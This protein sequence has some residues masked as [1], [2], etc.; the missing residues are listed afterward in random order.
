MHGLEIGAQLMIRIIKLICMLCSIV[1]RIK[2]LLLII[3]RTDGVWYFHIVTLIQK[4]YA[5]VLVTSW[6]PP[7][8]IL[9]TDLNYNVYLLSIQCVRCLIKNNNKSM[10]EFILDSSL[11]EQWPQ[12][13]LVSR[14]LNVVYIAWLPYGLRFHCVSY[15]NKNQMKKHSCYQTLRPFLFLCTPYYNDPKAGDR[16][17]SAPWTDS[18]QLLILKKTN[19]NSEMVH[20]HVLRK[21]LWILCSLNS[22]LPI[23]PHYKQLPGGNNFIY[24]FRQTKK[25]FTHY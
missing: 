14:R 8:F 15:S 12:G 13:S 18:L 25:Y 2:H 19:V 7:M 20:I 24:F 3:K 11:F 5:P 23:T 10:L 21:Y 4:P 22:M 16:T 1:W 6:K 9:N 17:V